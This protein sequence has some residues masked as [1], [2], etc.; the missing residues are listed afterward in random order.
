MEGEGVLLLSL[1]ALPLNMIFAGEQLVL[2]TG[3]LAIMDGTCS[4]DIQTV[5]VL[6]TF[7]GE[8]LSTQL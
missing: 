6:K 7:R 4:M 8:G 2:D 1:T 3:H 5:G